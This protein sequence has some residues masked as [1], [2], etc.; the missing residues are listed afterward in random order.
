M[1]GGAGH[2]KRLEIRSTN[3]QAPSSKLA[4]DVFPGWAVSHRAHTNGNGVRT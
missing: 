1:S 4:V 2:D 3:A